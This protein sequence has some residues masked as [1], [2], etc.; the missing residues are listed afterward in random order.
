MY[1]AAELRLTVEQLCLEGLGWSST[2]TALL[3]GAKKN[4][5]DSPRATFSVC[6]VPTLSRRTGYALRHRVRTRN[7][8]RTESDALRVCMFAGAFAGCRKVLDIPAPGTFTGMGGAYDD[9]GGGGGLRVPARPPEELMAA[10][11]DPAAHTHSRETMPQNA[12]L[13]GDW[14]LRVIVQKRSLIGV[15]VKS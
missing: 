14:G 2:E 3:D 10:V 8:V 4:A 11:R 1:R 9:D 7:V 5:R 12:V 6:R 13:I 15:V